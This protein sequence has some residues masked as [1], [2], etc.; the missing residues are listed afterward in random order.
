MGAATFNLERLRT[1]LSPYRLHFFS[2][3]RSTNDHAARLRREGRLFAPAV[4]LT[5]RQT[6]G[7]GRGT[8]QWWSSSGDQVLTV[9][10]VLA[11][12]EHL[13]PHELPLIAGIAVREAAV[14]LTD[15]AGIELKWPN[16]VL[17]KGRK[18]AG[19]LCERVSRADLIGVGMN[20]NLDPRR[21]P[22][23][24]REKVTSLQTIANRRID[25]TDAVISLGRLLW[26][27]T[28]RR[29][30]QPFGLFVEAYQRHHALTGKRVSI[31]SNDGSPPL[32]G[33]VREIDEQG[34]LVLAD[35]GKVHRI[36][37]GQV[38][39]GE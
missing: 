24:L 3:L 35:G 7:R 32:R 25:P 8:N 18:L 21:A 5:P 9:T 37:A 33:R 34:R 16:D 12:D 20:L 11:A 27:A 6:A 4:V 19:I 39:M 22:A 17:F 26:E 31:I 2:R 15:R 1:G 13:P 36:I 38:V 30:Q 23:G 10:F 28:R 29:S 14:E